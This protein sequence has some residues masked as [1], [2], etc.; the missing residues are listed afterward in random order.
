MVRGTQSPSAQFLIRKGAS[1]R[2]CTPRRRKS[3]GY[4]CMDAADGDGEATELDRLFSRCLLNAPCSQ[5]L[6]MVRCHAGGG[7]AHAA[8]KVLDSLDLSINLPAQFGF[9]PDALRVFD[10]YWGSHHSHILAVCSN[11]APHAELWTL[12]G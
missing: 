4:W 12:A 6:K 2:P 10:A 8:F 9:N 7:A 11:L 5:V 3:I 1:R